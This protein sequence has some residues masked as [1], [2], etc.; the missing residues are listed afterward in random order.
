MA[1]AVIDVPSVSRPWAWENVSVWIAGIAFYHIF[2][3]SLYVGNH[4]KTD[5]HLVKEE[6]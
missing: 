5:L 1:V 6:Y 3:F 4:F 2:L